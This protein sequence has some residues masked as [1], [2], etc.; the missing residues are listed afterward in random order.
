MRSGNAGNYPLHNH[1]TP[2]YIYMY[3]HIL[4]NG[5]SLAW[6]RGNHDLM[7]SMKWMLKIEGNLQLGGKKE[8]KKKWKWTLNQMITVNC[9]YKG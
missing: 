5:I 7:V 3:I 8:K 1:A 6:V 2:T 9:E 4:F